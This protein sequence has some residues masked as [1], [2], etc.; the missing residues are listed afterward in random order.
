MKKIKIL[1]PV[2]GRNEPTFRPLMMIR[3]RLLEYG[4]EIVTDGDDFDILFVGMDSFINKK[5]PL[6]ESVETGLQFLSTLDCEYYLFDGSDSTSLMGAYEVFIQS[7]AKGLFKNQLLKNREDYK[8]PTAH[9][10]WWFGTDSDLLLGYD[11]PEDVWDKINLS[12]YNLGWLNPSYHQTV[13]IHTKENSVCAIFQADHDY[14]ED[15]K[16]RNDHFYSIHRNICWG[17]LKNS[18]HDV[19]MSRLPYQEYMRLL[20]K[21]FASVSPFGMGEVCFR[22][23]EAIQCYSALIKPTMENIQTAPNIYIANETYV[24]VSVDWIDLEEKLDYTIENYV[25]IVTNAREM[26][27]EEYNVDKLCKIWYNILNR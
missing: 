26:F 18:S 24:P 25:D 14:N 12:G 3:Q 10:K 23:F 13:N 22:D 8:T 27:Y 9:G 2:K 7:N 11:I 20:V 19:H 16:S 1:N 17:R 15:H 5:V 4:I 6:S 21:S